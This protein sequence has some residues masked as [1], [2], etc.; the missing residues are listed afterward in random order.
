[1]VPAGFRRVCSQRE[2]LRAGPACPD[3][4]GVRADHR[5]NL[6][7]FWRIH[8]LHASWGGENRPPRGTTRPTRARACPPETPRLP[9]DRR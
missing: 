6:I 5:E 9:A 7:K 8:V 3:L 4:A 1:V 2:A